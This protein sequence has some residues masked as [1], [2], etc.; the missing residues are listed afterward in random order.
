MAWHESVGSCLPYTRGF[1][2]WTGWIVEWRWN[3]ACRTRYPH[4][5]LFDEEELSSNAFE[6]SFG[7]R[8]EALEGRGLDLGL[9]WERLR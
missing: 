9:G 3:K 5:V 7:L 1:R 8:P 2:E 4:G 6:D